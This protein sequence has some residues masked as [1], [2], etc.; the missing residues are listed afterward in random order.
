[1]HSHADAHNRNHH[2]LWCSVPLQVGQQKKQKKG[3]PQAENVPEN[4]PITAPRQCS[5]FV[6][7]LSNAAVKGEYK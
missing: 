3:A 5:V 7:S 6:L 4:K 2:N 1:M